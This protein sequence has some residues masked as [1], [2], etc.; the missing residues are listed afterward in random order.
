M[1][2]RKK[3][4]LLIVALIIVFFLSKKIAIVEF[5]HTVFHVVFHIPFKIT[6]KFAK[7]SNS[8]FHD[9]KDQK[10][11]ELQ[12]ELM[13]LRSERVSFEEIAQ[14]NTR[15]KNILELK[16]KKYGSVVASVIARTNGHLGNTLIVDKGESDGIEKNMAVI[17]ESGLVG[18]VTDLYGHS[19]KILLISDIDFKIG[20]LAQR[21]RDIGIVLGVSPD[22][23]KMIYLPYDTEVAVGD[24]IISSGMGGVFP[25]GILIGHV[26]SIKADVLRMYKI[27]FI[28]PASDL[29]RIEEVVCIK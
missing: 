11:S 5:T 8:F 19:A 27:A 18:R 22:I 7:K 10:I 9:E 28:K 4:P 1:N 16:K 20:A 14:E 26:E 25:K 6:S 12:K 13:C 17:T 2:R 29:R 21:T 3:F 24:E 15:L 23:L